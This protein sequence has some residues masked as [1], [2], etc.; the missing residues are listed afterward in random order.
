MRSCPFHYCPFLEPCQLQPIGSGGGLLS[1]KT[2]QKSEKTLVRG[3][4]TH[5]E[6]T[7][8]SEREAGRWERGWDGAEFRHETAALVD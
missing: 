6:S 4:G 7:G 3:E 1:P 2:K 8:E 5:E